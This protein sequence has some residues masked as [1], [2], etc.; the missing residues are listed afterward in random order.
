MRNT[1]A[2]I[3]AELHLFNFVNYSFLRLE[4]LESAKKPLEEPRRFPK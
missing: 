3:F 4:D 2:F 1:T